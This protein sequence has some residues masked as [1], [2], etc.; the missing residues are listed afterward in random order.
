MQSGP[1]ERLLHLQPRPPQDLA[2]VLQ[3]EVQQIWKRNESHE[4]QENVNRKLAPIEKNRF[5]ETNQHYSGQDD[6]SSPC[7]DRKDAKACS[8]STHRSACCAPAKDANTSWRR[9]V[10]TRGQAQ[11][12]AS[13][14]GAKPQPQAAR[15]QNR[16]EIRS[17]WHSAP[18]VKLLVTR[19]RVK[20]LGTV[21]PSVTSVADWLPRVPSGVFLK[22]TS[23]LQMFQ[24]LFKNQQK[25]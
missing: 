8:W 14:F 16:R 18:P 7:S 9:P 13:D 4:P 15:T 25:S 12:S 5:H 22:S 21:I 23:A 1:G 3:M 17:R 6:E 19:T 11:G 10:C 24:K 20:R 2:P